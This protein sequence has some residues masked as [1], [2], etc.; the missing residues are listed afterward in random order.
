MITIFTST[1]NRAYILPELYQS[2]QRQ[3]C[4][5]FEWIIVDD[6]STDNTEQIVN[7]WISENILD[8]SYI[9]V[10]NGG[11]QRAI[12]IGVQKAKGEY[13]WIVDSDDCLLDNSVKIAQR[14][15]DTLPKNEKFA[16]VAG[17]ISDRSFKI[18][19]STFDGEYVDATSLERSK[20]N[21]TG[22]KSEIFA[23]EVLKK[24]PFPKFEKEKFVP[25][26]LVWNR[27]AKSGYKLRWFNEIIYVTEYLPD[28]YSK[29]IDK[30]LITNWK[31]YSLY[32]KE[33]ISSPMDLKNKILIGGAYCVRGIKKL[34]GIY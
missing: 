26:A 4:R 20:Y 11:K 14:W 6:G 8:I 30:I 21:I 3:T 31:G 28:G 1:Y 27:I 23:T 16:G 29:N 17:N 33:V 9:K 22:D 32:V 12:N 19:G 5:D 7:E 15:I 18:I 13:F 10:E 24:F 25:E 2:L 34:C